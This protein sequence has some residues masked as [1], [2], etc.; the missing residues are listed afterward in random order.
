[1][2][3]HPPQ[4]QQQQFLFQQQHQ[5][6]HHRQQQ[7]QQNDLMGVPSNV[8]LADMPSAMRRKTPVVA[9]KVSQGV[10]LSYYNSKQR[11]LQNIYS[12]SFFVA[13]PTVLLL[14]LPSAGFSSCQYTMEVASLIN[15][16]EHLQYHLA[17]SLASLRLP[18][19]SGLAL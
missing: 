6:Q 10:P 19:F 8:M 3:Y 9:K 2:S 17:I 18:Y 5:H 15:A 7:Q 1:L 4:A 13:L 16:N 12:N 14:S 11:R